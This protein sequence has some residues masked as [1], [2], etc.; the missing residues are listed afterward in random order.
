MRFFPNLFSIRRLFL[1][2][3]I[4]CACVCTPVSMRGAPTN[5]FPRT[6]SFGERVDYQRKIGEVYWRHRIWPKER[7]DSKPPLEAVMSAQRIEEKVRDSLRNSRVLANYWQQPISSQQVQAEMERMAQQTKNP[8]MLRELFEALGNDPFVI[9]ECLV[10]P[11]LSER[12]TNEYYEKSSMP[13][14]RSIHRIAA[15]SDTVFVGYSLPDLT[16]AANVCTD[17]TWTPLIDVPGRRAQHT[18]VWTGSEMIVWGGV[19]YDKEVDTGDRYNPATDTWSK[20]SLTNAP[21]ARSDHT[22]VWTGM[23][24][25]VWGGYESGYVLS[26]GGRYDPAS[27]SWKPTS[28]TNAPTPRYFHTAV[29]T[30]SVMV[31]W[32]GID[33]TQT[34]PAAAYSNTGA[35]Y[36]PKTDTWTSLSNANAP[37]GRFEHSVVWTGSEMVVWGGENYYG[38]LNNGAKYNPTSNTWTSTSASNAPAVRFSHSAVWTGTEMIIWGGWNGTAL[39]DG[40]RY[41]PAT[42][43]WIALTAINPPQ[44]RFSHSAIWTG[45]EMIVWAGNA[46]GQ[47]NSGGRYNPATNT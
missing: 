45:G 13:G 4:S 35:L 17:N 11:A 41:N 32:G 46:N 5:A 6:L 37:P 38:A 2:I 28:G 24:M 16:S 43:A 18:S 14:S 12:L 21:V 34:N 9:A 25:V 19:N 10:R 15:E 40:A 33:G 8:D 27:D 20:V 44:G 7:S 1:A 47:T 30:G 31:V 36:D 26:S 3:A 39:S 42:D 23:E 29:W 22:A